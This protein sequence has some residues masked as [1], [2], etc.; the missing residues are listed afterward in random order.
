MLAGK[1]ILMA[2]LL[3]FGTLSRSVVRVAAQGRGLD[4]LPLSRFVE[5]EIGIG[6]TVLWPQHPSPRRRLPWMFS[7]SG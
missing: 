3:L 1:S 2:M 5:A 4:V 6:L 7:Q